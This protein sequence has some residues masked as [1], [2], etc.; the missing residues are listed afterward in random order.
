MNKKKIPRQKFKK[1]TTR[2]KKECKRFHAFLSPHLVPSDTVRTILLILELY[3]IC[4]PFVLC[5]DN[6]I[7]LVLLQ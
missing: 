7:L 1:K 6:N 3:A 4:K 2:S 5:T